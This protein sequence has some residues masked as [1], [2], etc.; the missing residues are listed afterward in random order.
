MIPTQFPVSE[1]YINTKSFLFA[2]GVP[3]VV[4]LT[5]TNDNLMKG[6]YVEGTTASD[7]EN[8][9]WVAVCSWSRNQ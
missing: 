7:K 2:I 5:M 9:R 3:R 6:K 4:H 1:W 8:C